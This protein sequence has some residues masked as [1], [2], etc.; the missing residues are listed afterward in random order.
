MYMTLEEK[1]KLELI[2]TTAHTDFD[3]G[4]NRRAFFKVNNR[5]ISGDLVQDTF[6]KTWSYLLGGGKI[7]IMKAFLYHVLNNLIIDQYR[8]RKTISLD[9]L[10]EKGFEPSENDTKRIYNILDGKAAFLLIARLPDAYR[11][12]MR[13]KFVQD[14]SLQEMSLLTGRSKNALAVQLHRGVEKLKKLYFIK[15]YFNIKKTAVWSGFFGQNFG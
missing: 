8:K 5:A 13:M 1:R 9:L 15:D 3:A 7:D 2:L 12:V 6:V 4:L 10:A 11:E 14:L